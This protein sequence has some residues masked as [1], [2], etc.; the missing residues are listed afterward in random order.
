MHFL[1]F[2]SVATLYTVQIQATSS[3]SHI[4]IFFLLG[5]GLNKV[6]PFSAASAWW[7]LD[8]SAWSQLDVGL[9]PS[10]GCGPRAHPL[11]DFSSHGHEG[12]LHICGILCAGFQKGD[13]Q[14]VCKFL[15]TTE[16]QSQ[17]HLPKKVVCVIYT[18]MHTHT[19]LLCLSGVKPTLCNDW[20]CVWRWEASPL[21]YV[22]H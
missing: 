5:R 10:S 18:Y 2:G 12:L 15:D 13:S 6:V 3:C 22:H 14:R 7:S 9:L 8:S 4:P 17:S 1:F 19:H 16:G 11:L 21:I 20:S